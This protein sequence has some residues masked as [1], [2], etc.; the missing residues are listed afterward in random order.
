MIVATLKNLDFTGHLSSFEGRV[1]ESFFLQ[2]KD[3]FVFEQRLNHSARMLPERFSEGQESAAQAGLQTGH[4]EQ[5]SP[6]PFLPLLEGGENCL[7]EDFSC[8]LP[9][10]G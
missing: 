10:G 4:L 8:L 3:A 2:V 7:C 5:P 9:L 1:F 6:R